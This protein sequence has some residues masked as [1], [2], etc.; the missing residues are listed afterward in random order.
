MAINQG[1]EDALKKDLKNGKNNKIFI[2][3]RYDQCLKWINNFHIYKENKK[4]KKDKIFTFSDFKKILKKNKNDHEEKEIEKKVDENINNMENYLSG[5][6]DFHEIK[7]YFLNLKNIKDILV[8]NLYD[9]LDNLNENGTLKIC[10]LINNLVKNKIINNDLIKE[11][12][13]DD[14]LVDVIKLD[15]PFSKD[16]F[17]KLIS[18]NKIDIIL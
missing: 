1:R 13:T 3:N 6:K 18:E 7:D 2:E 15:A 10:E 16:I 14:E 17:N 5:K 11:I 4:D 8:D 12:F 9:I